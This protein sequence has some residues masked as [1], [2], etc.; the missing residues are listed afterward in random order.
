MDSALQE[1]KD[2]DLSMFRVF[3]DELLMEYAKILFDEK[4]SVQDEPRETFL[5]SIDWSALL[6]S[7]PNMG[8]WTSMNSVKIHIPPHLQDDLSSGKAYIG[9]TQDGSGQ[10][11][12]AIFFKGE[13]GIKGQVTFSEDAKAPISQEGLVNLISAFS[14]YQFNALLISKL[15]SIE[16]GVK[17]V[18]KGQESDRMA[19]ATSAFKTYVEGRPYFRTE[20]EKRDKGYDTCREIQNAIDAMRRVL[21]DK[22]QDYKTYSTSDFITFRESFC[23]RSYVAERKSDYQQFVVSIQRCIA[24][25]VLRKLVFADAIGICNSELTKTYSWFGPNNDTEEDALLSRMQYFM[26]RTPTEYLDL[27]ALYSERNAELLKIEQEGVTLEVSREEINRFI[28][29]NK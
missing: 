15:E 20:D 16:A 12:S 10:Y 1:G 23:K 24:L 26:G 29:N 2:Y 25:E 18:L 7:I 27:K 4:V 5:S 19:K 28:S 6:A 14:Q 21:S 8:R 22:M 11:S 9:M 17:D 13:K 3:G